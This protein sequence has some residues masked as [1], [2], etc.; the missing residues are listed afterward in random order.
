MKSGLIR[1]VSINGM[2]AD[3][4][5]P[6]HSLYAQSAA[7]PKFV[8]LAGT[9]NAGTAA[10]VGVLT[11]VN[12]TIPAGYKLLNHTFEIQGASG[13][14]YQ[15]NFNPGSETDYRFRISR[16]PAKFNVYT[17]PDSGVVSALNSRPY[18]VGLTFV[19]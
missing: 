3:R 9:T 7:A 12:Y 15:E 11:E 17:S 14:W 5:V 13:V 16:G 4:I 8:E 1:K 2:P 19:L 18:R 6:D 10:G